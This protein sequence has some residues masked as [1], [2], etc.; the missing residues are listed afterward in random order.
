MELYCH[1]RTNTSGL[2][3]IQKAIVDYLATGP[4]GFGG[5]IGWPWPGGTEQHGEPGGVPVTSICKAV[6]GDYLADP[7]PAQIRAVQRAVRRLEHLGHVDCWH[8]WHRNMERRITTLVGEEVVTTRPVSALYVALRWDCEH[9]DVYRAA[10]EAGRLARKQREA[11]REAR[12]AEIRSAPEGKVIE[13]LA[14]ALGG[15]R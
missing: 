7:T 1:S 8:G 9:V 15:A 5:S 13:M 4:G 6:Y 2:G 11:E 10:V 12:H 3:K 14:G